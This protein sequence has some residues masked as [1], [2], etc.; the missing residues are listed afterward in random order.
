[1]P[2]LRV[3]HGIQIRAIIKLSSQWWCAFL[4]IAANRPHH[5]INYSGLICLPS[6]W[7]S[8]SSPLIGLSFIG[9]NGKLL[10]VRK[11]IA[12]NQLAGSYPAVGKRQH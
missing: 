8:S 4:L 10:K 5:M 2:K 6:R 12:R 11:N 9:D 1:M 7:H 3:A